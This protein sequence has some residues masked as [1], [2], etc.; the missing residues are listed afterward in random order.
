[1]PWCPQGAYSHTPTIRTYF[2][3]L[4]FFR[5]GH[6]YGGLSVSLEN[7]EEF[8]GK[9]HMAQDSHS[10]TPAG[11]SFSCPHKQQSSCRH[12]P[13]L[14][15][16]FN[17]EGKGNQAAGMGLRGYASTLW[18][19][20][21]RPPPQAGPPSLLLQLKPWPKMLRKGTKVYP[22]MNDRENAII[23]SYLP[24]HTLTLTK[25]RD[26]LMESQWPSSF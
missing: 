21:F 11:S 26:P 1:M 23:P 24:L 14:Q 8:P 10:P 6:F 2:S 20:P 3:L 7:S 17:E 16:P 15:P 19:N 13:S 18:L 5:F 12:S 9:T 22:T 4:N 25:R